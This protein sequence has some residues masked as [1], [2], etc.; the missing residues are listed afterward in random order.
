MLPRGVSLPKLERRRI[1]DAM[2]SI[3]SFSDCFVFASNSSLSGSGENKM[4]FK[5][6]GVSAPKL[7]RRRIGEATAASIFS[8]RDCSTSFA[9]GVCHIGASSIRAFFLQGDCVKTSPD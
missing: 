7:E 5:R 1:G 8:L 3:F 4:R 2:A 9:F 6:P